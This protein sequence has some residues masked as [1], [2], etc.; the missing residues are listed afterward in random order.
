MFKAFLAWLFG[1]KP[2]PAPAAAAA[3]RA[4]AR[5]N[6]PSGFH[7][8]NQSAP[9]RADVVAAPPDIDSMSTF[10]CRE[11]VLG[12]DQRIAGYQFMLQEGTRTRIRHSSRRVHHLYAEVLVRSLVR[13]DI[14]TLIGRRF[15][16]IDVPDS[17]VDHP[18][19]ATLPPHKTVLVLGTHA[20]P[21]APDI[22]TLRATVM[23]VR[24]TGIRIGLPDPSVVREFEPLL[25][26]AD[27]IMLRAPAVDARRGLQIASDIV[28][29]A[30][31]ARLLVRDLPGLEDFRF[32][33][34][35]GAGL[36]QGPFITSRESWHERDLGPNTARL[37]RL[38]GKVK[39]DADTSELAILLKEDAALSLRLLRYINSASNGL[40][41]NVSS[42]E[43]A[44]FL[45]GREK[46][47]RWLI[48]LVCSMDPLS[49]RSSSVLESA[50]VRARFLELLGDDRA[51]NEREEL[52][53]TG[54]LSLIDVILEVPMDKA[55]G[56]LSLSP[57]ID[58]AVRHGTG[59]YASRLKLA[60]ACEQ[61]DPE[62]I[63][64]AASHCEVEPR[65]ASDRHMEALSWA[66]A[67]Q[68][69]T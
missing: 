6:D 47:Y 60:I 51:P 56:H 50:L 62:R 58:L 48:L 10:L 55:I 21:G 46:L 14:G 36:F 2:A 19:I 43:R 32:C 28:A 29:A 65:V 66:M 45:I 35:L 69:G 20:D 53:L 49:G 18:C 9:L 26:L 59:P 63:A 37:T 15:A 13:A 7:A 24:A 1:R 64:Q 17:F 57:E 4:A 25:P 22:D 52:F 44:I 12:R 34:K 54:L 16:F 68:E 3:A 40:S 61:F 39:Q 8:L 42:I 67:I 11:A 30:P 23:R 27:F 38:I 41:E 5:D 33:Y 31:Q